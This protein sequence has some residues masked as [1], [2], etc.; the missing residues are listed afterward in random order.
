VGSQNHNWG[1]RHTDLYAWGQVAGFDNHP[2]SFLEAATARLRLG[3]VWTPPLTLIVLE[4]EHQTYALNGLVQGVRARGAF[5][6]F[7]WEF[8]SE[9]PAV[10]IA[11][12]ISAP[13]EAFVG[14]NYYNPPGGSK[15]CLNS[16]IA[17][18][19]LQLR[20]KAAGT[21]TTLETQHRAAFEILT[22]DPNHG[23]SLA[24]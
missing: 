24:A 4:H 5:D 15:H 13:R 23:V 8:R 10:E 22:N 17:S 2:G 3:P 19:R 12:T 6:Y 18:A 7:T 20:D 9:T 1:L 14:L 16:K 21:T 11:G